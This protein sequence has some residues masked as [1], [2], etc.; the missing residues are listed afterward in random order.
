MPFPPWEPATHCTAG[1]QP[2]AL[3]LMRWFLEEYGNKGG[4]NLGIYNCRTVRGGSTTSCHGE[5]RACDL[6]FPV[7][8]PDG[9]DCL[10]TLLRRP[11]SLGIQAIIYERR[12]YS[13]LSPSGRAYTGAVPHLDHLHVEL[14]RESAANLTYAT[15]VDVLTPGLPRHKPGTRS[16]YKGLAGTDVRWMQ[17]HLEIDRDGYFGPKTEVAVAKFEAGKVTEFPRLKVDGIV[18]PITWKALGVNPTYPNASS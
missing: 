2:G 15:I 4:Y 13:R 1:P 9:N 6:G 11:G 7:G 5:G 18:G 14:T 12:I 3:A 16:L 8:D 17:R 10:N